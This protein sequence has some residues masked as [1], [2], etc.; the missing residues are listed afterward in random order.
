MWTWLENT[1]QTW[2]AKAAVVLGAS[3]T[4]IA[5]AVGL[6]KFCLGVWG[7]LKRLGAICRFFFNIDRYHQ[8]IVDWLRALDRGQL[9]IIQTR[10][11][12]MDSDEKTAFARFGPNGECVW[13]SEGWTKLTGL[14]IEEARG[15]GWESGI[16]ENDRPRVL[17][18]WQLAIAHK[19][20]YHDTVI[21]VNTR[22]GQTTKAKVIG[23]PVRDNDDSILSW[24]SQSRPV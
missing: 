7:I 15:F 18:N 19:R 17:Q 14:S 21:Y 8:E 4:F 24:N 20:R 22:T 23:N 10:G 16:E 5:L 13:V 2:Q 6:K 3:A 11:H 12:I 1:L 9:D